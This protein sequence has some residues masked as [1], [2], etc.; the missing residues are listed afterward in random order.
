MKRIMKSRIIIFIGALMLC[1]FSLAA[2]NQQQEWQ[3]TSA[4]PQVGSTYTPQITAVGADEAASVATTTESYSPN[5]APGGPRRTLIG[6]G[7]GPESGQ[8]PTPLGDGLLPLLMMAATFCGVIAFRRKR[9]A[10]VE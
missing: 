2:D 9:G 1:Q 7:G 3:S 10:G 8:G 6:P 4:M 5:K